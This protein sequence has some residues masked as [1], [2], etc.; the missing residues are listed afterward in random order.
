MSTRIKL[1]VASLAG[2]ALTAA[3]LGLAGPTS[4]APTGPSAV[5][6]T[7][8]QLKSQGY[9]V[10][11]HRTGNKPL[12][13]CTIG[14]VRPGQTRTRTDH[15]VPRNTESGKALTTT[16]TGQTVHVDAQC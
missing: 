13:Q 15:G 9:N 8:G 5:E 12:D 11:L 14:A 2:C 16:I 10:V 7:V 3:A 6:Q 4:A 1:A